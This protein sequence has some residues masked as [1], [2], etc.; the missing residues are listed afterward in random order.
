[1]ST[2]ATL[3]VSID[4]EGLVNLI[5]EAVEHAVSKAM[6]QTPA[7]PSRVQWLSVPA[8]C[9]RYGMGRKSWLE[10]ITSGRLRADRRRGHG[11]PAFFVRVSDAERLL[12]P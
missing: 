5:A 3:S 9:K 2:R 7:K 1:M 10:L 4:A 8:G 11:G 12:N 6:A